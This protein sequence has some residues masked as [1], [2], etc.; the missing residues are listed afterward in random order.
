ME[1]SCLVVG[2]K[3]RRWGAGGAGEMVRRAE[4]GEEEEAAAAAVP[5][6]RGEW[7][8]LGPSL[9]V[10]HP[11][12]CRENSY[13]HLVVNTP[14]LPTK[15]LYL[16]HLSIDM[17]SGLSFSPAYDYFSLVSFLDASPSLETLT[18][19]VRRML[20]SQHSMDHESVFGDSSHFRQMPRHC[21]S[22]LKS[23][24]ISG[25][26][27]ANS[28][29]ELT[30]YILNN[31]VSLECLTLNTVYGFRCSDEGCKGCHPISNGV[32]KEA[33]RAAMA[34]RTC[35]E[36]K[37]PSAVKLTVL[38]PCRECHGRTDGRHNKM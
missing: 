5:A 9:H 30:C 26:S 10:G 25:F 16:K 31:A 14:M 29:V 21:H 35:I 32:L 38:G 6:I 3:R 15:F 19:N 18:L 17:G 34:I 4:I 37:V 36:D 1:H 13:G 2:K 24:K 22:C 20:I 8:F 27:S 33:P 28:L 11:L 12:T 7:R 23:V